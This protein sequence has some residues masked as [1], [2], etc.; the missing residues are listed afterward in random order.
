MSIRIEIPDEYKTALRIPEP[1]MEKVLTRELAIALYAHWQLPSGMARKLAGLT[2]REFIQELADRK[3]ERHYTETDLE[4]DLDY[5][6][7]GKQ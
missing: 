7:G 6:R 2:K 3:V 5:A 4:R 1:E